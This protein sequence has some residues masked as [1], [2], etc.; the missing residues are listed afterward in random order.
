MRD[1]V[2]T[3]SVVVGLTTLGIGS[4]LMFVPVENKWWPFVGTFLVGFLAHMG[5]EMAGL[6]QKFCKQIVGEN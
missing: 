3:E 6:N 5:F 2:I 4:A 1:G